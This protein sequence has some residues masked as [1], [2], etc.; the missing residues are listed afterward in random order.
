MGNLDDMVDLML[1]KWLS[2]SNAVLFVSIVLFVYMLFKANRRGDFSIVDSLRGDDGKASA[3]RI[4]FYAAFITTTWSVMAYVTDKAAD[5][6]SVVEMF[7]AYTLV[8]AAPKVLEKYID[9]K[10]GKKD[11]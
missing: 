3:A 4:V 1:T 11:Q 10:Y 5:P 7:I 2:P 6:R 9:A 8:W